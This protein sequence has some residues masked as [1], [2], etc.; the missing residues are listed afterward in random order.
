VDHRAA[1]KVK[2]VNFP[3]KFSETPCEVRE[4]APVLGQ[5]DE[6]LLRNIL[7]YDESKIDELK[8]ANAIME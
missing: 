3:V 2:V 7:G 1:G 5:H 4:A 6:D 8:K